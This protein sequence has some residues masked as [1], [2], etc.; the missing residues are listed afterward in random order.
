MLQKRQRPIMPGVRYRFSCKVKSNPP[1]P[2]T[3]IRFKIL[4]R[5][6]DEN[7]DV[8]SADLPV[9]AYLEDVVG[10]IDLPM[11]ANRV[12]PQV[13]LADISD[14]PND[15]H[16]VY[17]NNCTGVPV[18]THRRVSQ[19]IIAAMMK[20]LKNKNERREKLMRTTWLFPSSWVILYC[21]WV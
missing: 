2:E 20:Q 19:R 1:A 7:T 17:L 16:R 10:Y 4:Y 18:T 3:K 6:N 21:R 15:A 8:R 14:D 13:Q 11:N 12:T 9:S 5:Y